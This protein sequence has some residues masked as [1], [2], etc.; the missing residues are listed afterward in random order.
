[1]YA[2]WPSLPPAHATLTTERPATALLGPV[3]HRLDRASHTG[4][5][6]IADQVARYEDP[7]HRHGEGLRITLT[8]REHAMIAAE[9]EGWAHTERD[10]KKAA[11]LAALGRLA[12]MLCESAQEREAVAKTKATRPTRKGA[13]VLNGCCPPHQCAAAK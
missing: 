9:F 5:F 13:A 4:A 3:L 1:M 12:R 11:E 7:P 8:S 2:S 6:G 10:P